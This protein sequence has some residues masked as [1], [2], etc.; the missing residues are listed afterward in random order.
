MRDWQQWHHSYEDPSSSLSRR[1]AVVRRHVS[2]VLQRPRDTPIRAL[3]LCAG[4]GRDLLPALT[5]STHLLESVVLVEKDPMLAQA[6]RQTAAAGQLD[7]VKVI[8][9]DASDPARFSTAWP[10]D[11]LLLCGIFGNISDQ[12]IK[13]TVAATPALLRGEG[14]VIWTRGSTEPD[15]RPSVRS[16]FQQAGLKEVAFDSEPVGYGVGVATRSPALKAEAP[17]PSQ[18][19]RFI[20]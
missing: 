15:L 19:F 8:T 6:A 7:R 18:L 12:D 20:R 14:T 16:W 17:L 13:T 2:D 9:G 1:L 11:L 3:S 4:D 5:G 10:V